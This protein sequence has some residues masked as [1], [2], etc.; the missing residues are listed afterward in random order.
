[1]SNRRP[2]R[3]SRCN[4]P[5]GKGVATSR[6]LSKYPTSVPVVFPAASTVRVTR[7]GQ[8]SGRCFGTAMAMMPFWGSAADGYH[9]MTMPSGTAS[10][11]D[12][13]TR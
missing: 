10:S 4:S 8:S 9:R 5:M 1:M 11:H 6:R 13:S 7:N 3:R 2:S 12:S